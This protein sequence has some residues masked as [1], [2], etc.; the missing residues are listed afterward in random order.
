[1]YF[2]FPFF[3]LNGKGERI[4]C[5]WMQDFF[6]LSVSILFSVSLSSCS[7]WTVIVNLIFFLFAFNV[8]ILCYVFIFY[9]NRM[10]H[11]Y[12]LKESTRLKMFWNFHNA[13]DF[14][15]VLRLFLL[16]CIWK[17]PNRLCGRWSY[18][19]QCFETYIEGYHISNM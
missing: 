1:M 8:S 16:F 11:Y 2:L 15:Y 3:W 12:I 10:R 13:L 17:L 5:D 18:F 14:I 19:I 7:N 6:I 9:L 4:G